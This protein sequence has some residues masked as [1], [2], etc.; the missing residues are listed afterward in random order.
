MCERSARRGL[1]RDVQDDGAGGGAAHAAI[2]NAHHVFDA[3]ARELPGDRDIARLGH[4]R[5]AA[6]TDVAQHQDVIALDVERLVVDAADEVIDVVEDHGA[7]FVLH[8]LRIGRR[9]LDDC[10]A[11]CQVSA[12][13][14]DPALRVDRTRSRPHHILRECGAMAVD[15]VP[16]RAPG[17]RYGPEVEQGRELTQQRGD[18]ARVMKILHIV[19]A[20]GLEINEHRRVPTE[21]VDTVETELDADPPRDRRQMDDGVGRPANG[22]QHAQRVLE[23]FRCEDPIGGQTRF[24][25][26]PPRFDPCAPQRATRSAVTAGGDAPPGS[27]MPRSALGDAGHRAGRAHHRT[28]A[29]AG[30]ERVAHKR[31]FLRVDFVGAKASPVPA[32][33]GARAHALA[34]V[35]SGQHRARDELDGGHAR[36]RRAHELRRHGL[37]AAADEGTTASI[38]CARII[39]SVSIDMRLRR[40]IEVGEAKLSCSEI[41]G[42]SIGNPP[43]SITPRF[44]ASISC[45]MLP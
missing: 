29:D 35:R 10:A 1:R 21:R 36:G 39:S 38:G 5:R 7:T 42:K 11:G 33:I 23:S 44:T 15:L 37:V 12:Q 45:G 25:Q 26:S 9:L 20:R 31:D 8:K 14:R 41:V 3:G 40:Y 24:L 17:H 28:G 2:R 34:T 13:D 18:A 22:E 16:Q 32:A 30:N 19:L 6:R 27:I 4:P 43:A